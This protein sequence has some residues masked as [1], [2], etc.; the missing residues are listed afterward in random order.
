MASFWAHFRK[1]SDEADGAR[2]LE[3]VLRGD[4]A[5][6]ERLV[7][8]LLPPIQ[9]RV[10]WVLQRGGRANREDVLDYAQD[11]LVRLFENE[12]RVLRTWDPSRG[13]SLETFAALVA[14]RYVISALRSGKKSA[15]REDPTLDLEGTVGSD[16]RDAER[17]LSSKDL[18]GRILDRLEGELTPRS[19]EL[20]K[21][22]Y[23]DERPLE[24]VAEQFGMSV[25]AL[26]TWSS[27]LRTRVHALEA[28]LGAER[29][30][31]RI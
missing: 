24:Q 7:T 19:R 29:P 31:E 13:A 14:E 23:V 16:P 22:L 5:A 4:R 26:Y 21:A 8:R 28:E 12:H 1:A 17:Q 20:F 6:A 30:V 3:K 18:L 27:R 11:A 25:N 10:A 15:W 9:R 2:H